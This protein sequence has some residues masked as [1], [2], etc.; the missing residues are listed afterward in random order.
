M[1]E[2]KEVISLLAIFAF[3]LLMA[4]LVVILADFMREIG[5][6]LLIMPL[7]SVIFYHVIFIKE[8]S[9]P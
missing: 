8:S 3:F 2:L 6:N 1:V 7:L 9:C 4:M 5:K